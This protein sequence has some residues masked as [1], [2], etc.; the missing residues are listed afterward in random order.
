MF[1]G[2]HVPCVCKIPL[3][4]KNFSLEYRVDLF[5]GSI[6]IEFHYIHQMII[7]KFGIFIVYLLDVLDT[8]D[9]LTVW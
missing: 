3:L 6:E 7:L 2:T 8:W 4:I 5:E 1:E 9:G